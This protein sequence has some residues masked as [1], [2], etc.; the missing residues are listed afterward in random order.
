VIRPISAGLALT[1]GAGIAILSTGNLP[2][3]ATKSRKKTVS[4]PAPISQAARDAAARRVEDH[5]QASS[6]MGFEQPAGMAPFFDKL[7]QVMSSD[8]HPA[9]HILHFGDSHTAADEWTGSLRYFYQQKF[10]NGGSGYSLAGHPFAGYRRFGTHH[11]AT[12]GWQTDGL[13]AGGDGYFGLGGVSIY[14]RR[15]GQSVFIEAD[16]TQVE[17]YYLQMPGGGELE[18]FDNEQLVKRFSTDGEIVATMMP[19]RTTPG[20]H[21][22]KLLTVE[23]RPVRLLGWATDR[24]T[25]VTYESLG[26]NG[27]QASIMFRWKE[28][29]LADDLKQR[30]PALIVL[31]YGSNEASDPNWTGD[32]YQAMFSALLKRLRSD[33]PAASILVLGPTDR[34]MRTRAGV[35]LVQGID[36]IITAQR[37]ACAE[38]GCVY[39]NAKQRMGGSGTIRD[40]MIAGL[41]QGDYVHFTATGY[42]RLAELLFDDMMRLYDQYLKVHVPV[43]TQI[44]DG[45]SSQSN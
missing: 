18:L 2:A 12:A 15:A 44:S 23:N 16:C 5:L 42:D 13:S 27:A 7:A 35:V 20:S 17:V 4:R 40:W 8:A 25:G 11:G 41:G 28:S 19:Y 26:I 37:A 21:T 1:I 39:W 31:A 43:P 30:N 22:L 29:M 3:A 6:N 10:G 36:R 9:V 33:C 32:S 45:Q 14:T 38:N 24:D 34:M